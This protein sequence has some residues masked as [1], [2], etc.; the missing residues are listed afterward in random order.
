MKQKSIRYRDIDFKVNI[1]VDDLVNKLNEKYKKEYG[2]ENKVLRKLLNKR[3]KRIVEIHKLLRDRD[4]SSFMVINGAKIF[5]KVFK[6]YGLNDRLLTIL[7]FMDTIKRCKADG[8]NTYLLSIGQIPYKA[9]EID[10]LVELGY[11]IRLQV[12]KTFGITDKG[13]AV[14][15][16]IY[17]AYRKDMEF[18]ISNRVYRKMSEMRISP[19]TKFSEEERAIRRA[20][21]RMLMLPF[22]ESGRKLMPKDPSVRAKYLREWLLDKKRQG[23]E[24]D[25]WYFE[26]LKRW[27]MQAGQFN[28]M[29]I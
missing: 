25:P 17:A 5:R 11:S 1:G 7:S 20:K 8:L 10:K 9:R 24:V 19:G 4:L 23:M 6:R 14:I 26:T 12:A 21:Y 15:D 18:F 22:W 27:Y 29:E 2:D 3:D 28:D 16:G 13:K